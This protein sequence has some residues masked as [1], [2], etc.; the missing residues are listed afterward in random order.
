MTLGT[1]N[2]FTN[3][4]THVARS[5]PVFADLGYSL[6]IPW[7]SVY[8]SGWQT[9]KPSHADGPVWGYE[10]TMITKSD[11]EYFAA[12][13]VIRSNIIPEINIHDPRYSFDRSKYTY[14]I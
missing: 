9:Q 7:N 8:T 11:P 1:K 12:G 5:E 2:Y 6:E 14:K 10:R 3:T 13:D 4:T